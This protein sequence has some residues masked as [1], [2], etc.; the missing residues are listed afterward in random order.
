MTLNSEGIY[1]PVRNSAII[2]MILSKKIIIKP[3]I[4]PIIF[5]FSIAGNETIAATKSA[6]GST[7]YNLILQQQKIVK[8]K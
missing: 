5:F 1:V 8:R 2:R 4:I 3:I 7:H 6:I